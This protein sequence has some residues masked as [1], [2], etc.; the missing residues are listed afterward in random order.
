MNDNFADELIALL[1]RLRR[2]ALSL[3]RR[4]ALADDL[5]Q[6]AAERDFAPA[7][8]ANDGRLDPV[9]SH[10][11]T[12]GDMA[13]RS[14]S[15]EP[16]GIVDSPEAA[17]WTAEVVERLMRHRPRGDGGARQK[18]EVRILVCVEELASRGAAV[19][20]IP[21]GTVMSVWRGR[22]G[23]CI[24]AGKK[25]KSDT[26]I[27]GPQ[28]GVRD[29]RNVRPMPMSADGEAAAEIAACIGGDPAGA[30]VAPSCKAARRW[31]RIWGAA[32]TRARPVL[33]HPGRRLLGSF[34]CRALKARW[35]RSA[36]APP[37]SIRGRRAAASC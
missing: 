6:I 3:C 8:A 12:H 5:V 17:R 21:G 4:A 27:G 1:P 20:G 35:C 31:R 7:T 25:V 11:A 24:G 23:Q 26:S 28:A 15:A 34:E 9:L 19:R 13:R 30:R 37:D 10:L 33:A 36:N 32:A 29:D 18:R 16:R 22:A 2:Y 14:R